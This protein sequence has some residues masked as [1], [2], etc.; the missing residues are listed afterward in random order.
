VE[1]VPPHKN[2]AKTAV[3]PLQGYQPPF[4]NKDA[5]KKKVEGKND[6]K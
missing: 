4:K 5:K 2:K 1:P 3:D 6:G